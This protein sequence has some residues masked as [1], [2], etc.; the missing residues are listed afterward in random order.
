VEEEERQ[1]AAGLEWHW[2]RCSCWAARACVSASVP[3]SVSSADAKEM[4]IKAEDVLFP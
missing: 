1:A 4:H 3:V 2:K